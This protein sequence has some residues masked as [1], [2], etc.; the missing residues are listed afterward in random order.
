MQDTIEKF[1]QLANVTAENQKEH[2]T[3]N[4]EVMVNISAFSGRFSYNVAW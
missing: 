2:F 4:M 1:I 3:G